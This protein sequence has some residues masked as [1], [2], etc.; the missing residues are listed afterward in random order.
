MVCSG[1]GTYAQNLMSANE[2]RVDNNYN[3]K[4][5]KDTTNFPDRQGTVV[6]Y[7]LAVESWRASVITH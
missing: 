7:A 5:R 6:W 3:Y 2:V 1:Q 4:T